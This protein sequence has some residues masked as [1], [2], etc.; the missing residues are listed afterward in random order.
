MV[1]VP[2]GLELEPSPAVDVDRSG[3][4][5]PE[6]D[7][8]L[9]DRPS[10]AVAVVSIEEVREEPG[11]GVSVSTLL[12]VLAA[13]KSLVAVVRSLIAEEVI[14][15]GSESVP[16]VGVSEITG[17]SELLEEVLIVVS[18][19][20][21]SL[22]FVSLAIISLIISL[23]VVPLFVSL[24][25]ASLVAASLVAASLVVA[26][27]AVGS[28]VAGSLIVDSLAEILSIEDIVI[29]A[30]DDKSVSETGLAMPRSIDVDGEADTSDGSE[31]PVSMLDVASIGVVLL[32]VV[33]SPLLSVVAGSPVF[34]KIGVEV[35]LSVELVRSIALGS[36]VEVI[37]EVMSVRSEVIPGIMDVPDVFGTTVEDAST[38]VEGGIEE[39]K[40]EALA[41]SDGIMAAPVVLVV[42]TGVILAD[43]SGRL[44][45]ISFEG[46][47]SKVLELVSMASEAGFGVVEA[48]LLTS[49]SERDKGETVS[50]PVLV[51]STVGEE[52]DVLTLEVV[53]A[54]TEAVI[55]FESELGWTGVEKL[56]VAST[57]V[58]E[59]SEDDA[60]LPEG[61]A[62]ASMAV[63][64][65]LSVSAVSSVLSSI[66]V[67]VTAGSALVDASA[68]DTM[69]ESDPALLAGFEANGGV[70][71]VCIIDDPVIAAGGVVTGPD[72]S[73]SSELML[74]KVEKLLPVDSSRDVLV[75]VNV[76]AS[77]NELDISVSAALPPGLGPFMAVAVS[78]VEEAA[79]V[80]TISLGSRVSDTGPSG[81]PPVTGGPGEAPVEVVIIEV[82][83]LSV[84][85]AAPPKGPVSE[86]DKP[87]AKLDVEIAFNDGALVVTTSVFVRAAVKLDVPTVSDKSFVLESLGSPSAVNWPSE[88]LFVAVEVPMSVGLGDEADRELTSGATMVPFWHS[89]AG[90]DQYGRPEGT[91]SESYPCKQL[92]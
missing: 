86:P 1:P 87:S 35:A 3:V 54:I 55:A 8:L 2:L 41:M 66:L 64:P 18:T 5:L 70:S 51:S 30:V 43:S 48:M 50:T 53:D 34:G 77:C 37:S 75:L 84:L 11:V 90:L 80:D 92:G 78:L 16:E 28:L 9:I 10:W 4:I 15:S 82:L 29:I 20:F 26:S 40:S 42:S 79:I 22:V 91:R 62:V 52:L 32:S 12:A 69:L 44:V 65:D 39:S 19:M 49:K 47:V 89:L 88:S 33:I 38:P 24:V 58:V 72:T 45:E 27:F 81:V 67:E 13:K 63:E 7:M 71:V 73:L 76:P 46:P 14:V 60:I 17:D 21:V 6:D 25:V 23:M 56:S 85:A 61:V 68:V 36:V 83:E 57:D 59:N 31:P 74:V